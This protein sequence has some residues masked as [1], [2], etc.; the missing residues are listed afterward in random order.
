MNQKLKKAIA[1]S[2]KRTAE[3]STNSTCLWFQYQPKVPAK[4]KKNK[5]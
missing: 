3:K 4:L 5:I 1:K 2:A